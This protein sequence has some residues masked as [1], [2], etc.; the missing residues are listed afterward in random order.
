MSSLLQSQGKTKGGRHEIF[1]YLR[2]AGM[3]KLTAPSGEVKTMIKLYRVW[4]KP[5]GMIGC[6]VLWRLNGR[7]RPL[8]LSIPTA[9]EKLPFDAHPLSDDDAAA[10]WW[11]DAR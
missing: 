7:S 11:G 1:V 3:S 2:A 5:A 4:R 6:W 9:V 8:D 10:Y